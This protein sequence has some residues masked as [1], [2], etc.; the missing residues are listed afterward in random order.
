MSLD[1]KL[2]TEQFINKLK[3]IADAQENQYHDAISDTGDFGF[4]VKN[5]NLTIGRKCFM[6]DAAKSRLHRKLVFQK[7]IL[8]TSESVNFERD[9][10]QDI[11]VLDDL[12]CKDQPEQIPENAA[13]EIITNAKSL[14]LKKHIR[15]SFNGLDSKLVLAIV[16]GPWF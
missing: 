15:Q 1:S 11:R 12:C 3:M 6:Y 13:D 4:S 14:L 10:N 2:P 8:F 9:T 16:I 7:D 5:K